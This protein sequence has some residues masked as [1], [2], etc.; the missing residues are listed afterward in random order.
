MSADVVETEE[1]VEVA[2]GVVVAVVKHRSTR[3]F[4]GKS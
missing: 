3:P 1:V 2:A 4:K